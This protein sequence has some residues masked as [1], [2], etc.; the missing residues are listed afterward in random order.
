MEVVSLSRQ[1]ARFASVLSYDDLP[2]DVLD[3]VKG[4]LLHAFLTG[5]AGFGH[6]MVQAG[7]RL[8]LAEE[9]G[10]G[11]A[12]A[13]VFV[14]GSRSTRMGAAF[15]N[16]LALSCRNQHDSYRM[17]I[18]PSVMVL[19][20]A[21]A[22]AEGRKVPGKEFLASIAAGYEV[23]CR[24][25][26]GEDYIPS[27]QGRGFRSSPIYG[28]FGAATAVGRLMGLKEDG[29]VHTLG[30]AATFA[31][32]TAEGPR[33]GSGESMFQDAQ[34]TRSGMWAALMAREG[35]TTTETAIDGE[36]GFYNG[37]TGTP[38]WDYTPVVGDLRK[39]FELLNITSKAYPTAGFNQLPILL[40]RKLIAEHKVKPE[41]ITKIDI[42]MN[43]LE[44]RYPHPRF[45]RRWTVVGLI[46]YFV[47]TAAVAGDF[48]QYRPWQNYVIGS[49]VSAGGDDTTQ[50]AAV[51]QMMKKIQ[52]HSSDRRPVYLP[53]ITMRLK[54][55][56]VVSG[57]LDK[58]HL[59]FGVDKEVELA[60]KMKPLLGVSDGRL[61]DVIQAVRHFEGLRDVDEFIRL[62]VNAGR[63]KKG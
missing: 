32:G 6:P 62:M 2:N 20:A 5:F 55:G 28:I 46:E 36:A 42:E 27:N 50:D 60:E 21:F 1:L 39:R 52:L 48:P 49:V 7:K 44:T 56:R 9:Q 8:A 45:P 4:R 41:E 38:G 47:A 63:E 33:G 43:H 17:L 40:T 61:A 19:P 13:T 59:L 22:T 58:K 34:A 3:Q 14:E 31:A 24:L 30:F 51:L 54:D 57:E 18:H 16:S 23:L 12:Q 10:R 35:F 37:F 15:V 29:L 25:A 11:D 26:S 53:K